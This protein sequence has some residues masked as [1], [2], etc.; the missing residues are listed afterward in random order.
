MSVAQKEAKRFKKI[1]ADHKELVRKVFRNMGCKRFGKLSDKEFTFGQTSDF[2]D[3]YTLE[4]VIFCIEYTATKSSK[5]GDHLKPKKIVYD[6]I[7]NDPAGFAALLC[8]MDPEFKS[9]FEQ[10]YDHDQAIVKI[11]YCS[12]YQF[13]S[14]YKSIVPNPIYLDYPLARYFASTALSIK[15]SA[16][17]EFLDFVSI[18]EAS[19]GKD[20]VFEKVNSKNEF[21]GALL[22]HAGASLPAG[23]EVVSFYI[24]PASLLHRVYVFRKGGW[25]NSHSVYQRMVSKSK[26][27]EM[28][29]YLRS[30]KR[31]FLNNI[32]AV[33]PSDT[34]IVEVEGQA[35]GAATQQPRIV[36]VSLPRRTNSIGL[37]DGQHRTYSY[38]KSVSDDPDI[39]KLRSK[40]NLLVTGIR[41]P[42]NYPE[43]DRQKFEANLFKEINTKQTKVKSD[44]I[45]SIDLVLDPFKGT[46]VATR[47]LDELA[48]SGGPLDS[49]IAQYFFDTDKLKKASIISYALQQLVRLDSEE[50]L[51]TVWG[52]EV[53][54]NKLKDRSGSALDVYVAFCVEQIDI[55]LSS[56]KSC[57]DEH[58]WTTDKDVPDRVITTTKINAFLILM[59]K[60]IASGI[61]INEK[62]LK[63]KLSEL[64]GF[65]FNAFHSSRYAMMAS[66]MYD[67]YFKI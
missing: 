34:D 56:I 11:V 17:P 9:S 60:L 10:H 14:K 18:D 8:S 31:V 43:S 46:S 1:Q 65:E 24:D 29:K 41:F 12:R 64:D 54:K 51:I 52:D 5:V 62:F 20:G 3:V 59:R 21:E 13:E 66:E 45:Q 33:L 39:A 44:L 32:I 57:V 27:D 7:E 6:N 42:K 61:P 4:N 47:V 67:K 16:L 2:D 37:I 55:M 58:R 63:D 26:I 15:V 38:Y 22:P 50:S 49:Y 19:V 36:T 53:N 48:N 23:F 40:Q 28:R 30:E 35:Q 25:R